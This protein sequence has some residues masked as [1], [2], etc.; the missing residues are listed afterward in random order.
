MILTV[1]KLGMTHGSLPASSG[2][3]CQ[4]PTG[5]HHD[6]ILTMNTWTRQTHFNSEC[7]VVVVVLLAVLHSAYTVLVF[8]FFKLSF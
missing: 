4:I 7:V 1:A 3:F 2:I 6:R 8:F 5:F